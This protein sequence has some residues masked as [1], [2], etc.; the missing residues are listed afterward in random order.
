MSMADQPEV[1]IETA[2]IDGALIDEAMDEAAAN[3]IE[4]HRRVGLPLAVWRNGKVEWIDA[5]EAD[6]E[7]RNS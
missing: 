1:D 5:E 4:A 2:M 6:R 3:A 7:R